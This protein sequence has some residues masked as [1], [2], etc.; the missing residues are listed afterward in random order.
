MSTYIRLPR[1]IAGDD[2][3]LNLHV[4]HVVDDV[5]FSIERLL[6]IPKE[7]QSLFLNGKPL[8]DDQNLGDINPKK[9][10]KLHLF[11]RF[12]DKIKVCV[13]SSE[14]PGGMIDLEP[15]D[16]V[17]SVKRKVSEKRGVPPEDVELLIPGELIEDDHALAEYIN[18]LSTRHVIVQ[19]LANASMEVHDLC[20]PHVP[21]CTL[22]A[23]SF[24]T[25]KE[26]KERLR[27][28]H[29]VAPGLQKIYLHGNL[30][31][32]DCTMSSIG[33]ENALLLKL[34]LH[35]IGKVYVTAEGLDGREVVFPVISSYSCD[36]VKTMLESESGVPRS[37]MLLKCGDTVVHSKGLVSDYVA[38]DTALVIVRHKV[39]LKVFVESST[40]EKFEVNVHPSQTVK[41]L[42]AIIADCSGRPAV[43]QRLS[44]NG[45]LLNDDSVILEYSSDGLTNGSTIHLE[46]FINVAM[47]TTWTFPIDSQETVGQLKAKIYSKCGYHISNQELYLDGKLLEDSTLLPQGVPEAGKRCLTLKVKTNVTVISS[48]G[49]E[50]TFTC[51]LTDTIKS[52][53]KKIH[54]EEGE[55]SK[56]ANLVYRLEELEDNKSLMECGIDD[57]SSVTLTAE[58]SSS[59]PRRHR[60]SWSSRRR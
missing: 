30:L 42:K 7:N 51:H 21:L 50:M 9:R 49:K 28:L 3:V 45:Q 20:E 6:H 53:K 60:P 32:D 43:H 16:T 56:V 57:K 40:G 48:T 41:E 13:K 5:K 33:I 14:G 8:R 2:V 22:E 24:C 27:D 4:C 26:I 35:A 29:G 10:V 19:L 54:Q 15:T 17:E 25:I 36:R 44:F 37:N 52:I 11:L 55:R 39:G 34:E 1:S 12:K 58:V 59:K 46:G 47:T 31:D 23:S 18:R 38:E